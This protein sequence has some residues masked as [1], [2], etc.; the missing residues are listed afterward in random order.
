MSGRLE[1]L[2]HSERRPT[3]PKGWV[4]HVSH[5]QPERLVVFVHGFRGEA[6]DTWQ[7]FPLSGQHRVWWRTSDM[8][9]VGYRS[10]KESIKG[11]ADRLREHLPRFYPR[12][13][14]DLLEAG[15]RRVR[16]YSNVPYRELFLVGHS[17]GGVVV[18]CALCDVA[19]R[20]LAQ[21]ETDPDAPKP[22]FL[23]AQVRLFSPAS[24]GFRPAG[25]AGLLR[26]TGAWRV[27]EPYLRRSSAYTDLQKDSDLLRDTRRRTEEY[28]DSKKRELSALRASILWANPEDIVLTGR[29]DS[30]H[31][32]DSVE[33]THPSVCKPRDGFQTPWVFVETGQR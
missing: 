3:D 31:P 1:P 22:V 4:F 14:S 11:V 7:Q 24:A 32:D 30:D 25:W 12:L 26:A 29:Y 18:R 13:P 27:A 9:F 19:H 15:G 33:A 17:L 6:V 28:V 20:W 16:E 5:A 21:L 10:Q 8:V 23:Q 2:T